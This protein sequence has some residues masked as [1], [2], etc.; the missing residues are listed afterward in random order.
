MQPRAMIRYIFEIITKM[1]LSL[2][3]EIKAHT[4]AIETEEKSE[5]LE[6]TVYFEPTFLSDIRI[7]YKGVDLHLHKSILAK[8]SIYFRSLFEG[9]RNTTEVNLPEIFDV[10]KNAVSVKTLIQFLKIMYGTQTSR[11]PEPSKFPIWL[12]AVQLAHYFDVSTIESALKAQLIEFLEKNVI[13]GLILSY[14]DICQHYN[15]KK[16]QGL[17]EQVISKN[18][19]SIRQDARFDS[20]IWYQLSP[21]KREKLLEKAIDLSED[22]QRHQ[23]LPGTP[24]RNLYAN[25][26]MTAV[27]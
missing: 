20:V 8:E 4:E 26:D 27:Q 5:K 21:E 12:I 22:Y 13:G 15:W 18:L 11:L 25:A 7:V 6:Y 9:D 1:K 3:A 2:D 24:A 17:V 14:L 23:L 10:L 19:K 16:E